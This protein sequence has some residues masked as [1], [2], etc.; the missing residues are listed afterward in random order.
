MLKIKTQNA[1]KS[2]IARKVKKKAEALLKVY[3]KKVKCTKKGLKK[4]K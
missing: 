1:K 2:Y 3:E 4:V